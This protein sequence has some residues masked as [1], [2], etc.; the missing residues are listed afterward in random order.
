[1]ASIQKTEL[2]AL[3]YA[4]DAASKSAQ[5]RFL[6]LV[7]ADLATMVVGVAATIT[8]SWSETSPSLYAGAA[9]VATISFAASA[10]LSC[11]IKLSMAEQHW[12]KGRAV[13]ESV[14]T[15]AWRYATCADPF[16]EQLSIQDADVAFCDRLKR[17]LEQNR[18][19]GC[20]LGQCEGAGLQITP[21]MRKLRQ[22]DFQTRA[23][24]YLKERLNDQ[25][26]WYAA[27]AR[28]CHRM[29]I[30]WFTAIVILQLA[31]A[32]I[33]ASAI[34]S[35]RFSYLLDIA[36]LPAAAAAAVLAWTQVKKHDERAEAYGIAAQDLGVSISLA[37]HVN[38]V[39]E[40][41]SLVKNA[42]K[43]ISREHTLWIAR[44]DQHI[45]PPLAEAV[46]NEQR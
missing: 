39:G 29:A 5:F 22:A 10:V 26:N 6:L 23:D 25:Q 38:S 28:V 37:S 1:M 17:L 11:A 42:E 18:D 9:V 21:N 7:A 20:E 44:R 33:A 35:S 46:G 43:A 2:P 34:R 32:T 27:K 41:A 36:A 24:V 40:L 12:Y 14:K 15:L 8:I 4:A 31:A 19:V 13:A 45:A 16:P 30:I 3:F